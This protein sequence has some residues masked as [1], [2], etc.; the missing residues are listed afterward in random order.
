VLMNRRTWLK[1]SMAVLG[2]I[3]ASKVLSA[4]QAIPRKHRV[5]PCPPREAFRHRGYPGWITDLATEPDPTAAWPSM[6]LDKRLLEDY[7]RT[8]D[9]MKLLGFNEISIWGLYVSRAWP[10]RIKS[11]VDRERSRMMERLIDQAHKHGIRVYS[12]LGVYSWGFEEIIEAHPELSRGSKQVMCTSNPKSWE[13]MRRVIDLVF[14]RFPIDGVSMQSADQGRCRC[15]QCRT[16]SDAE[17]HALLN[18]RAAEY[19]RSRWPAKTSGDTML[20]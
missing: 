4:E 7:C 1:T 6:R 3:A 8:F 17:Y 2:S 14:E 15:R 19:I 20:G 5:I 10:V 9:L 11:S 13:W 16:Y 12:G 18:V